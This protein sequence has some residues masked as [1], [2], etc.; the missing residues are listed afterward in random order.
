MK[1]YCPY[2]ICPLGAHIDHQLGVVSGAAIN[3]GI[4]FDYELLNSMQIIIESINYEG[5]CIFNINDKLEKDNKWY[6]YFKGIIKLLKEKYSL[7]YGLKGIF[8]ADLPSGGIASSSASQISFL[9]AICNVNNIKLSKD[10]IIDFVYKNER[11]FMHLYVGKLDPSAQ[12]LSK[13]NSLLFLDTLT[14]YYQNILLDDFNDKYQLLLINT[15]IERKLVNS[16]YNN[17]VEECISAYKKLDNNNEVKALRFIP[18]YLFLKNKNELSINE[19][20]RCLHFYT[21]T[22]RVKE[23]LKSFRENDMYNFGKLM[24]NSC[25]S[26]IYNYESG[27]EYLINLF[28]IVKNIEGVLGTR[29]LGGGFN[30]SSIALICKDKKNN[31]VNE[32][33]DKYIKIYPEVSNL[34][35]IFE[36]TLEDGVSL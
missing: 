27:S 11:D 13:K 1:T 16:K 4:T 12:I 31:I 32:I 36:I 29:F 8:K 5:I 9:L 15:G 35:K 25:I 17:R 30:G 19:L 28:N 24:T 18:E 7:K 3:L 20:K 26:S 21:E 2:R 34:F 22:N 33:S 23:G 6:D 14:G 10:E